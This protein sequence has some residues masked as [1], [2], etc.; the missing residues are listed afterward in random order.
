MIS[1]K[2]KRIKNVLLILLI[3][4]L[5]IIV[6]K[7]F[8]NNSYMEVVY[9]S[10]R[11]EKTEKNIINEISINDVVLTC[12]QENSIYYFPI[13]IDDENKEQ[14]LQIQIQSSEE[15]EGTI[16]NQKFSKTLDLYEKINYDK[17][18]EINVES[19]LYKYKCSIKFTNLPITSLNCDEE[20]IRK[21][22]YVYSKFSIT[23]PNYKENNEQYQFECD[24]KMRYRGSFSFKYEKKSFRIK[25]DKN[26]DVGLLGMTPS[27]TWILDSIATDIASLRPKT[28]SELWNNMNKDVELD[29][30]TKLN[31]EYV[32]VYINGRYN[33]IYLLKEVIDEDLLKLD[34]NSGVLVKGINKSKINFDDYYKNVNAE[35]ITPFEIKYPNQVNKYSKAWLDIF[36][37]I[38][39]YYTGNINYD[40][41]DR[42]FYMENIV[43][44]KIFILILSAEDNYD[45][46]NMYYSIENDKDDTKVLITPWD[47][48]LTFGALPSDIETGYLKVDNVTEPYGVKEDEQFKKCL[49]DRWNVLI[50][51]EISKEKLNSML[52]EQYEYLTKGH[53]LE[54]ENAKFY[55][56]DKVQEINRIKDW[57]AKRLEVIDKYLKSL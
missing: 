5:L 30:T 8:Y 13:I 23:D 28:A 24:S 44:Y 10:M 11:G 34:K 17:V 42:T 15:L 18:I 57:Y 39:D 51:S 41:I 48:D 56:A 16:G 47:L 25:L 4:I 33:G 49:R 14:H 21:N 45:A 22:E 54:R 55:N 26:A 36:D 52:D 3:V 9:N 35:Y 37:K 46:K 20:D 6:T 12:D 53:A 1:I 32:E 40:V 50:K 38:R 43:N 29:K 19:S 27:K 7:V 2:R 31:S